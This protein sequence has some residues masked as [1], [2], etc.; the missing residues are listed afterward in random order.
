MPDIILSNSTDVISFHLYDD[1]TFT[2]EETVKAQG[3]A[4]SGDLPQKPE[5]EHRSLTSKP[6]S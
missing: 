3:G 4:V 2:E 6:C 5:L 1:L